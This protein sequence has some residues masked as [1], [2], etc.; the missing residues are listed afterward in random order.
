MFI[1]VLHLE[2]KAD[3]WEEA[4]KR[5]REQVFPELEKQPGFMRVILGGEPETG[6][7][8]M[9]TMWQSAE[10]AHAFEEAGTASTFLHRFDEMYAKEPQIEGYPVLFDREF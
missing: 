5:F 8:A 4:L 3:R 1:R 9:I 2:M 6:R 7:A 10:H